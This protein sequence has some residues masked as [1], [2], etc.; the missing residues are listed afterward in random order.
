MKSF[1][2]EFWSRMFGA[3]RWV[4]VFEPV[5]HFF[6]RLKTHGAVDVWV[7]SNLSLAV[8]A[9]LIAPC[10]SSGWA[11]VL[12]ICYAL[13]RVFEI[14]IYQV[15]VLLFDEYRARKISSPYALR[16]YRRLVILLLQN[17]I[18]I[19]FWFA[20]IYVALSIGFEFKV[21]GTA[22]TFFGGM[23]S[24]FIIMTTFGEPNIA[25]KASWGAI[26][27]LFQSGT[28][29]FMTLLSLARFVSLIPTP[30]SSDEFEK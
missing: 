19:V 16:G 5:R 3:L 25:P 15:N 20:A 22:D 26:L 8:I 24:S 18:E 6:P 4:S 12:L 27:I 30:E 13:L 11:K 9:A 23:Y 10:V 2:V 1:I 17:Y 7:L 28:G 21:P 14:V 29:L